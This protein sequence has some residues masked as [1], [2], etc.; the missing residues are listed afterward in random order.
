M[1]VTVK[2]EDLVYGV[3]IAGR[4]T[5][6]K[7]ALPVLAGILMTTI[8]GDAG[9]LR[10]AG[11][12]GDH[13]VRVDIPAE[14]QEPGA[15]VLPGKFLTEMVKRLPDGSITIE[16]E[17]GVARIKGV[18]LNLEVNAFQ[19]GPEVFPAEPQ[20]E[21]TQL[22]LTQGALAR[23]IKMVA[24][25]IGTDDSKPQL[26][27]ALL[28]SDEN[29]TALVALNGFQM[30]EKLIRDVVSPT[31]VQAI[32]PGR[33]LDIVASVLQNSEDPVNVTIGENHALFSVNNLVISS[34]LINGAFPFNSAKALVKKAPSTTVDIQ[35]DDVVG[36]LERC[37]LV[38]KDGALTT[39]V[40]RVA[41]CSESMRLS[42]NSTAVGNI[43]ETVEA[44]TQGDDLVIGFNGR[45]LSALLKSSGAA[46]MHCAYAGSLSAA[47]FTASEDYT[48]VLSPIRL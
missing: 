3:L 30:A 43:Q 1:K 10:V 18:G 35:I 40:V 22:S 4:I 26:T 13:H 19:D 5:D 27:G 31:P 38:A 34:L 21:G 28:R 44:R 37:L 33:A 7:A 36:A 39:N 42:A 12:N 2:Y 6:P 25:A 29:E 45:F 24:H 41:V 16:V 20:V 11:A 17:D 46:Q 14:V 15:V 9:H 23:A 32:I 8:E 48:A 47:V